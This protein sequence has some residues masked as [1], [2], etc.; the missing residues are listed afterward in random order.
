MINLLAARYRKQIA[1]VLFLL[2]Y[3][4]MAGAVYSGKEMM[5][6]AF[7]RDL[8]YRSSNST[9]SVSSFYEH[10]PGMGIPNLNARALS[11][12]VE[13]NVL[14][15]K[16]TVTNEAEKKEFIGG[17]G[18]PEMSAFKSVGA[19]NM[20]NLFTGD[21]SYNVPLLDVGGYPVNL[22]YNAGITMDQEASWVGLGWNINPGTISRNM[23]GLPDDYNGVDVVTKE[24][25]I[26]PDVTVGVNGGK[27]W[28]IIGTPF[29]ANASL[30]IF[31]NNHRGIGLEAGI[32]GEF[33]IH[34]S[35][36]D[37]NK[38]EYTKMDSSGKNLTLSGGLNLNS[39]Q[40]MTLSGGV[41]IKNFNTDHTV[42]FGLN[43]SI[44]YSSRRGLT[45]LSIS[46]ESQW[47]RQQ[48]SSLGTVSRAFTGP[49]STNI[50]F[51]RSSF[52]PSI[53]MPMS[54]FNQ[55]YIV[56]FGSER[57]GF[58]K[59]VTLRGYV[60]QTKLDKNDYIQKKPA[61]GYMYYEQANNN[62]NA[63]M[64][65][66]RIND[67][68]YTAKTPVIALPVYTYD[69]FTI[70][71][72]GTGG[73]FRGY[74]D[75]MGYV[76]DNTTKTKTGVLTVSADVGGGDI[77]HLGTTLGGVYTPSIVE[78]WKQ[79]N[80]LRQNAA[81][82]TT[83]GIHQSF[84]F[85]NPGER[86]IIDQEYYDKLGGDKLIRPYLL[87]T[88]AVT[89]SLASGF[90][91]FDE[92][93]KVEPGSLQV[94]GNTYRLERDKRT[95][96]IT[97]FTAEEA[98]LVGLD[99]Q[100][101]SYTENA[102]VPGS[103]KTDKTKV[104][105]YDRYNKN[106]PGIYA[107]R[108]RHHISEIDVLETDGRRYVYGIPAYQ[109]VQKEVSFATQTT[110]EDQLVQYTPNQDNSVNNH[111]GRDWFFQRETTNGYAH[112]FL[113]TGILSPDYVDVLGDGISDDD[114][115]TAVKFNYSRIGRQFEIDNPSFNNFKWRM[116]ID[117]NKA[118]YNEG[119]KADAMDD[120]GIYSYGEKEL[121]YMHSIESKNMVAT[122]RI[123]SRYDGSSLEEENGGIT[124]IASG[125]PRLRKLDRIDLYTKAD[126]AKYGPGARPI[127]TVHFDYDYTLCPGY[128]LN[129]EG[130]TGATGKLTLKK[131]YFTYNGNDRVRKNTYKFKY[132]SVNPSYDPDETDRWGNY[133]PHTVNPGGVP[134][135]DF[136]YLNQGNANN[137]ANA[138]AWCLKQIIIPSGAMINVDYEADDYA[139]VQNR[140]ASQMT[141]IYGFSD[142]SDGTI[143]NK[144][145]SG[146]KEHRFVFFQTPELATKQDIYDRYL[147]DMKQ[148]LLKI[149]VLMPGGN[150]GIDPAYEPVTVYGII[151]DYNF[152]GSDHEKFYVELVPV[153]AGNDHSPILQ[154]VFQFLKDQLPGRAY[155]GYEV[156]G[157]GALVQVVR[158]VWGLM[159]SLVEGVAG[160]QNKMRAENKCRNSNLALS[161]ARLNNYNF[162]KEGGGHRI[163]K[164]TITDN[165][166]KMTGPSTPMPKADYG[167]L[168][169]YDKEESFGGAKDS[170]SSSGV[171]SYE[172]GTGA[173]ENPFREVL[174]YAERPLLG[175][176]DYSNI[177][178][179]I[180][181]TF[182][183]APSVGYS[184]VTVRSIHKDKKLKSGIG[185]QQ[186]EFYT[187][188][189]FPVIADFTS[190]DDK[191]RHQS[192]KSYLNRIFNFNNRD[193]MTLTQGFRVIL[194]DMNGKMK[195]QASYPENDSLTPINYTQY[196]Y[197]TTEVG[198]NKFKLDN[199]I[200][201]IDG[202][203]G[204]VTNKLIGKEI[205]I[206]NDF[207]EHF[208][209]TY[210]AN[211]TPNVDVFSV[212]IP[213]LIP[214]FF[215]LK[216]RDESR[217]RSAT[218]LKVINEFG[219]LD[220]VI[221]IDKG[222]KVSTKNMVYDAETGEVLLSRTNNEFD[223]P[224]YQFNYPAWWAN[225]GMEQA[226]KN[227]DLAYSNVFFRD[228]K[229]ESSHV[230][231]KYF[232]SG[233]EIY[234]RDLENTLVPET[235]G[236]IID[237]YPSFLPRSDEYRIWAIDVRKDTRNAE[238]QFIFLDR[239]GN[240]YN[241]AKA[242]IRIIRS[243]KRNLQGAS[244]GNIVSLVN[245]IKEITEG[246]ETVE[247]LVIDNGTNVINAGAAEFKERWRANDQFYT[248]P[249][250]TVTI[251]K[252]PLQKA[253]LFAEQTYSAEIKEHYDNHT[254]LGYRT[255]IDKAI[256]IT[257]YRRREKVNPTCKGN[258]F[259][260][261]DERNVVYDQNSW[262]RFDLTDFPDL[263]GATVVKGTLN[264]N[265]H[266]IEHQSPLYEIGQ[267][268]TNQSHSNPGPYRTN[269]PGAFKLSRMTTPW[270]G[271]SDNTNWQ[272][273][274]HD[275]PLQSQIN[276]VIYNPVKF[277]QNGNWPVD[278]TGLAKAM[279]AN[280]G[281]ASVAS[282]IKLSFFEESRNITWDPDDRRISRYCFAKNFGA[283]SASFLEI[284]FYKCN[285]L[286]EEVYHG[287][288][289][290]APNPLPVLPD[291]SIYC[292][293]SSVE[294]LC[295]SVFTKKRMNPYV[296]G[297][298]GNW[299]A[300]RSYVY[301]GARR[302]N[303][304]TSQTLINKDG[305]IDNFETYWNLAAY[306]ATDVPDAPRISKS[307]SE[308]WVWNSEITQYNR[309]GAELENRDP[310]NRYN[311]GI[312]GYQES[313]PVAV[314]NNSRLRLAAFDGFEDYDYK[315][316][317]CEPFCKPSHRH[318]KTGITASNLDT[319]ESHSGKYS[320]KILA[321]AS[322]TIDADISENDPVIDPD[323]L[324][325]T[326]ETSHSTTA[327]NHQGTGLTGDYYNNK[328]WTNPKA[329]TRIDPEV[330]L[331][332]KENNS[333]PDWYGN[334]PA[335]VR[336]KDMTVEWTGWLVA[337][338]TGDYNFSL[339]NWD[340]RVWVY[341][342]DPNGS[343]QTTVVYFDGS[344]DDPEGN[345]KHLIA[346]N[347]Y[348]IKVNYIQFESWGHINLQWKLPNTSSFVSINP[349]YSYPNDQ[350]A[351]AQAVK[352]TTTVY[353]RKLDTIQAINHN[354]I[355]SFKLTPGTKMVA[356]VWVKQGGNCNCTSYP[357]EFDMLDA[358]NVVIESIQTREKIIEG[359]Q[360]IEAIF[361]VPELSESNKVKF[362][363]TAS[364][365]NPLYID[366]LRIH[367][368]NANMKSFV[369]DPV[370]LRLAAE[371]DENNFA[372]FYEYDDEGVLVRVKK[373]TRLGIKTITET[374]SATQNASIDFD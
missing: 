340:N 220:S 315:D 47:Y 258:I 60:N 297:V 136:P 191:S 12:T 313:L 48:M 88:K 16:E 227:I 117:E 358:G 37:K 13:K 209:Y 195:S 226:Y 91:S 264:L 215:R 87:N 131:V 34:K 301:Y 323:I 245:P 56:K 262:M 127:K 221:N 337:P 153:G 146:S 10:K 80:F 84:Y 42:N 257:K 78:E 101:Y 205:E 345:V 86:A 65:F 214:T 364:E 239:Y 72:E 348:K 144:L 230:E 259:N 62:S 132:S 370:T 20:V 277:E 178:L 182:F 28:E 46:G 254:I 75:N 307:S 333:D 112:S 107:Y 359:W 52:T 147:R 176:T 234:V 365:G 26:K 207:R 152:V 174:N 103:C 6:A 222:S 188:K 73:S 77:A 261:C 197:R 196:F 255:M 4:N 172:P 128:G 305:V 100:I 18:Q 116:P 83:K 374:R 76:R 32:G 335:G 53:R 36:S 341:V 181:E 105:G 361:T 283:K 285:P 9:A 232:E 342:S 3:G 319:T 240:P 203:K 39:Q 165:W 158:S 111:K 347:Y 338:V 133:K 281:N 41:A 362:R 274:F 312:Y 228:G 168:Y 11:K 329:A 224:V 355:E 119:L 211:F 108:K 248:K 66:N 141:K 328:T 40:G 31:Y 193:Y 200:P 19:D 279:V 204:V 24:Q 162:H 68:V 109:V 322:Y 330:S 351:L 316:D 71:G 289:L 251:R 314:V 154:T 149:W 123:S 318:F 331:Y 89:P 237:G 284:Q 164:I 150:I 206:M 199:I 126:Y 269:L 192:P 145:Y 334:L 160:F 225:S 22:F 296:E 372:T 326:L 183:P 216:F 8:L 306:N 186:T 82:R 139:Y 293:T 287:D 29:G 249:T 120:K 85:K 250:T 135:S 7:E 265:A 271:N 290:S 272:K 241:S 344:E 167:Q 61:F 231:M 102:F 115:G 57:K 218:T 92:D 122:F 138:S 360:Q 236:C 96:I 124:T 189:D 14:P 273:I 235:P 33:T 17:P 118:R 320:T 161:F 50:S 177:E 170:I 325:K 5:L 51:A 324:I 238:K 163:K 201:V 114:L 185:T 67:R 104:I 184:K 142:K 25:S 363:F 54:T 81:F 94:D 93:K 190:F 55:V 369:Y 247:K 38:T 268:A 15:P 179:P 244:I 260:N 140:R 155:P 157:D 309:K 310:L 346:G 282:G 180:A 45:D 356:S 219:I 294:T 253:K 137:D 357:I 354:L 2:F 308:K 148:L 373:E 368:F 299:R 43:T 69:V 242:T 125:K 302:E 98:A 303:N 166:D 291:D 266:L 27:E 143:S 198:E 44:S 304:P 286:D 295:F 95:Q 366:D 233:D 35:L 371:L 187:T 280:Y 30:G 275:D 64:D 208:S 74:R 256:E 58:F 336:T 59:N 156:K 130:G 99:K 213:V 311:A 173:E 229:I 288:V 367:P 223:K 210:S 151:K 350:E 129:T 263:E 212:G 21:F 134:N 175:P 270:Y 317:P 202:P 79:N 343:N 121:W 267:H 169:F 252:T 353:C 106:E 327:L 70:S 246:A 332:F 300:Y 194:N 349:I 159:A 278:V 63:L 292:T 49:L 339:P 217:F 97:T 243:G 113:L 276:R 352:V 298:L 110:P 171:A 1:I 90:Q 23:R 321:N